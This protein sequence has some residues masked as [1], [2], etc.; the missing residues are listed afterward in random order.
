MP[1]NVIADQS[2]EHTALL[3]TS[4]ALQQQIERVTRVVPPSPGKDNEGKARNSEGWYFAHSG[5]NYG[6]RGLMK[7]HLRHGY[8][9]VIL[10]NGSN[11]PALVDEIASRI[12]HAYRWDSTYEPLPR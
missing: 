3:Q 1:D 4:E 11:G 7:G 8:G 2:A 6:F 5:G 12:A 10:T 9:F